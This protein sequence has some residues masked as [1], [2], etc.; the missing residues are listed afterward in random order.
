[1][2]PPHP[3][4]PF[5]T[6]FPKEIDFWFCSEYIEV[7]ISML[8]RWHI[9]ITLVLTIWL[10]NSLAKK[11]WTWNRCCSCEVLSWILLQDFLYWNTHL[12][13]HS[14]EK[15]NKCNQ[16]NYASSLAGNFRRHLKTHSAVV[17]KLL[18]ILSLKGKL[19]PTDKKQVGCIISHLQQTFEG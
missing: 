17:I 1:M 8:L 10:N 16:I 6:F 12:K 9:K 5:G 18:I 3:T 13:T 11:D 4:I 19:R 15:P 7:S 14:G 2:G